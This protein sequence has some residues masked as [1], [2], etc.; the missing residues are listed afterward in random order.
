VSVAT[1]GQRQEI[2]EVVPN[3]GG[4]FIRR[5]YATER[6]PI[7]IT[8]YV[9]LPVLMAG[10]VL[11][12]IFVQPILGLSVTV[13][14]IGAF[15]SISRRVQPFVRGRMVSQDVL[16][17]P[18]T[19]VGSAPEVVT[20]V[21]LDAQTNQNEGLYRCRT[22]Q[23]LARLNRRP[24]QRWVGSRSESQERASPAPPVCCSA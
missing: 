1:P 18:N 23:L 19:Y 10:A 8:L 21:L 24:V 13:I 22:H 12:S 17:V 2:V 6:N 4:A 14:V 11:L 20:P 9:L 3:T 16:E 5:A 7:L 15:V